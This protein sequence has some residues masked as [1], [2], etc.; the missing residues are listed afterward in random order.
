MSG[1]ARRIRVEHVSVADDQLRRD[2]RPDMLAVEEPVQI[3]V[4]AGVTVSPEGVSGAG[5]S[6][7]I[8]TLTM[9]TPGHDID[10]AL[11][12]L[13]GEGTIAGIDDVVGVAQRSRGEG[14]DRAASVRVRLRPG[15]AGP[16]ARPFTI[17][18]ACGVCGADSL[19]AVQLRA[20]WDVAAD[21]CTITASTLMALP[22][23]LREQQ[24]TFSRTGGLHAAGLFTS[25]GTAVVVREDVGRHNAVDKVIGYAVREGLLPLRGHV[26]QVS[27]RAS[28]ELVYKAIM[29]GVPVLSA[30]S[31]PSSLA[32]DLARAQGLTLA[33]FV[34]GQTLNLYARPDRVR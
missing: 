33:G 5:G 10:L 18:S 16:A 28:M 12:W 32:V 2:G 22:R 3:T 30:V 15:L 26:L 23:R 24:A 17:S 9:R 7:D 1:S 31:A 6:T 27:G 8:N 34:R 29:A 4:H 20:R 11:G 14:L 19:D 21:G 13:V 25:D